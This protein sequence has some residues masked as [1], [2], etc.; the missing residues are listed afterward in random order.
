MT[1]QPDHASAVVP[2]CW[3]CGRDFTEAE[4]VRLGDHPEVGVCLGCANWLRRRAQLR[5]DEQQP[6]TMGRV[7]K[8][9]HRI[10][11]YVISKGWH[12]RGR[13]GALLR[14]LDRHLP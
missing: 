14:W 12:E 10:R 5:R 11:E 4:L 9:I 6:S 8:A 13:L 2:R 7:R 1:V 3:C